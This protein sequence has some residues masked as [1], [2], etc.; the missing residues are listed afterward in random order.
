MRAQNAIRRQNK[1]TM[2]ARAKKMGE[3]LVRGGGEGIAGK[4]DVSNA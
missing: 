4:S 2:A 1:D 3:K